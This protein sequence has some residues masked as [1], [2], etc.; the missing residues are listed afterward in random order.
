MKLAL[1]A[2]KLALFLILCWAGIAVALAVP[3]LTDKSDALLTDTRRVVLV[4]GG[5]ATEL[6]KSSREWAATSKEQR[7]YWQGLQK[8]VSETLANT[9]KTVADLDLMVNQT[10][11][12]LNRDLAL[13]ADSIA[14]GQASFQEFQATAMA[15]TKAVNQSAAILAGPEMQTTLKNIASASQQLAEASAQINQAAAHSNQALGHVDAATADVQAKVHQMTR[16]VAWYKTVGIAVLS[17]MAPAVNLIK[18]L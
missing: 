15:T 13:M 9:N 2:A 8:Q 12:S 16:P 3:R 11:G 4:V 17:V 18:G 1:D 7:D 5:A 6:E 14:A 10:N